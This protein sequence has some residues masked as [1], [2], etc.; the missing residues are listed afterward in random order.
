MGDT[1]ILAPG[2]RRKTGLGFMV[3]M[4]PLYEKIQKAVGCVDWG[5]IRD[6]WMEPAHEKR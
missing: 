6:V 1:E 5:L 2:L 4:A 3:L